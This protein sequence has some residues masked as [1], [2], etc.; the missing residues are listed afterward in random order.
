MS[1]VNRNLLAL[2][3]VLKLKE[4]LNQHLL[5]QFLNGKQIDSK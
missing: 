4:L 5:Y 3:T 2:S 1:N